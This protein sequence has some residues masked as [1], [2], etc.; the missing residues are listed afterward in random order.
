MS[1]PTQRTLALLRKE[2]YTAQVVERWIPQSRKRL[3]LFGVIDIVACSQD[4]ILGIQAT[5]G[6]N[7]PARVKKAMSE[8]RLESWLL[9]G[10]KFEVWGWRKTGK[11]S[12]RKLWNV[13][14]VEITLE[15]YRADTDAEPS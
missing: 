5:S 12:K 6:T 10:G 7:V 11:K 1:S 9:A 8:P 13:R 4:G 15:D 2:G 3:D 14:K